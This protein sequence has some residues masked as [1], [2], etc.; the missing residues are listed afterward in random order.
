MLVTMD[1]QKQKACEAQ[2]K[3]KLPHPP[4][5]DLKMEKELSKEAQKKHKDS[6][7]VYGQKYYEENKEEKKVYQNNIKLTMRKKR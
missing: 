7:S 2:K 5:E 1:K 4:Q 6:I 3:Y